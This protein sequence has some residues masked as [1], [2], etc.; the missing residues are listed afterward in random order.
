MRHRCRKLAG[1][2]AAV[3]LAAGLAMAGTGTARADVPV[4]ASWQEL[5]NPNLQATQNQVCVDIPFA[6]HDEFAALWMWTC[7]ATAADGISQ[8]WTFLPTDVTNS[9][10]R[11]WEI[12][13]QGGSGLCLGLDRRLASTPYTQWSD[14]SLVQESCFGGPELVWNVVQATQSPDP[15]HQVE[16][17]ST[18][19]SPSMGQEPYCLAADNFR[20]TNGVRVVGLP[21][22]PYDSRQ[23]WSI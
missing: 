4:P 8:R 1:L 12:A 22:S 21:C 9:L 23:W 10:G 17:I 16:I 7:H 18:D 14:K 3:A 15:A 19:Y 5:Y 13:N 11:A 6:T 2:A 20:D